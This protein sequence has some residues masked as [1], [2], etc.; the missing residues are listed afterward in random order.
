M[1]MRKRLSVALTLLTCVL[2]TSGCS[3]ALR[4]GVSIGVTDG[5]SDGI[6]SLFASAF[7][8]ISDS[9]Y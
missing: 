9:I 4:D 2:A 1:K 8:S 3:R 7:N 5:L 6:A